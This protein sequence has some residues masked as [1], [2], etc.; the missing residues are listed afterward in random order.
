MNTK[1]LIYLAIAGVV[2]Y[3]VWKHFQKPAKQTQM[4]TDPV[5]IDA[6]EISDAETANRMFARG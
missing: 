3:F 1:T 6:E 5:V 4:V 2:L